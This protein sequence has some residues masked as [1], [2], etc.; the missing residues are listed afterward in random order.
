MIYKK[1]IYTFFDPDDFLIVE[2]AILNGKTL[3]VGKILLVHFMFIK[4]Y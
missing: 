1:I 2:I 4:F 3:N